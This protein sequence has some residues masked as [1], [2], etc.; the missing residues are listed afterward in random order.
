MKKASFV[1]LHPEASALEIEDAFAKRHAIP[2]SF[3]SHV[4]QESSL[5]LH[6]AA[7]LREAL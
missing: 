6:D 3:Q 7:I 4:I 2:D 5:E 1:D